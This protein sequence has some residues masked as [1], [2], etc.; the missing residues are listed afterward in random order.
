[1]N[2]K[3]T[4]EVKK[5]AED[6]SE[7]FGVKVHAMTFRGVDENDLVVGF[8][9]EPPFLVKAR[10]MDKTYGG[11]GFTAGIEIMEACLIKD[12]TDPRILSILPVNDN[13]KMGAAKFCGDLVKLA[14]DLTEKKNY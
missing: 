6:L 8:V 10:A 2:Y 11:M 4:E 5:K 14:L 7:K 13:F 3:S 1:M 9:K 12:E